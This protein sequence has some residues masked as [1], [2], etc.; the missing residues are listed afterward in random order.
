MTAIPIGVPPYTT[1]EFIIWM[2]QF[3]DYLEV[4][5]VDDNS[6][7]TAMLQA[8]AVTTNKI[9]NS[10]IENTK[11]AVDSV[12]ETNIIDGAVTNAKIN[13]VGTITG[14][15]II[16]GSVTN[17]KLA[18]NSVDTTN[19]FNAT[20]IDADFATGS[21]SDVNIID[22]TIVSGKF[23]VD[24]ITNNN[25][26]DATI[27]ASFKFASST[28]SGNKFALNSIDTINI[29]NGTIVDTDIATNAVGETQLAS[30][31]VTNA[32]ILN[33]TII[34]DDFDNL[35]ITNAKIMDATLTA[36]HFELPVGFREGR[37]FLLNYNSDIRNTFGNGENFNE[38]NLTITTNTEEIAYF[39]FF[40]DFDIDTID[41]RNQTIQSV[42][43]INGAYCVSGSNVG[44]VFAI[45]IS[46]QY[47]DDTAKTTKTIDF[48]EH[49]F[50]ITRA[51]ELFMVPI[52]AVISQEEVD[53]INGYTTKVG[54]VIDVDG[55]YV[56]SFIY[57]VSGSGTLT[58]DMSAY[59][60]SH[61]EMEI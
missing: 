38:T 10:T 2:G 59:R 35:T 55:S 12:V 29:L 23:A 40:N 6:I 20:L 60:S 43:H 5:F 31:A 1:T 51:N 39:G 22:N 37:R 53:A 57:R 19:I 32:K 58:V 27:N 8:N 21:I 54:R 7:T 56:S 41:C 45:T 9:A 15:K 13:A 42:A 25:I 48:S 61:V 17:T 52:N 49:Y 44:D 33:S 50:T 28:I 18:I 14:D 36:P 26:V 24:S 46:L 34:N 11:L 30:N 3:R 16:D 47:Y 4:P